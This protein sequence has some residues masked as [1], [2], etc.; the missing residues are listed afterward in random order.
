MNQTPLYHFKS[1]QKLLQRPPNHN[2]PFKLS[3]KLINSLFLRSQPRRNYQLPYLTI[4]QP[5][6]ML[7]NEKKPLGIK[8]ISQNESYCPKISH[9]I[10]LT[11]SNKLCVANAEI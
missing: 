5:V 4:L 9:V 11:P 7:A 3:T 8:Q 6:I 2:A 1:N 10:F